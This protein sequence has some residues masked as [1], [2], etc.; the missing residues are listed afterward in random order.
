MA[1]SIRALSMDAVQKS[2]SGHPGMP[3]GFA[4]VATVLFN[5]FLKFNPEDPDW[6]D[7]DRFILSAG[8]GSMLLYS[9]LHLT[10]YEDFPIEQIRRFRQL[11][12]KTAGHPEFGHGG[13]IEN[14]TGP[15]GQGLANAVGMAIAEHKLRHE[16][17]EEIINHK[18][19]A[20]VGDGCLMEG[21]SYEA[22]SLAG[23]LKLNQLIVLWDDNDITIDGAKQ[24]A[25]NEDIL[26][27][28]ESQQWLTLSCDGHDFDSIHNALQQAQASVQ[29]VLIACKTI[30]G[31]GAVTHA[32]TA[33]VHGSPLGDDEITKAKANLQWSY[34]PFDI[35]QEIYDY[36]Q[37]AVK[38]SQKNYSAWQQ[39]ID[40]HPQCAELFRRIK[41]EL[42]LTM[43]SVCRQFK[44]KMMADSP[45][46]ATRKSGQLVL[47][48]LN[49]VLPE[50]LGGSADLT[51]SNL[52]QAEGQS[53]Y[54]VD[55]PQGSYIHFGI[56]EHGM[57]AALN[58][59]AL[60]GGFIPYGGTFLVFSDYCR[61][62][63]R[64]SALM[65]VRVIYVMTHDSI[66]L[67]EDG[68]T[69][70]PVETLAALRAIP[71]LNVFRPCDSVETMECWQ[72]ALSDR[73]R[74]TSLIALSRQN[75]P[76][77]RNASN[78]PSLD[79]NLS[80]QG[81]YVLSYETQHHQVTIMATGSE[82]S[83]ALQ[84][85]QQLEQQ[86]IGTR[87]VSLPQLER[88]QEN[89][90]QYIVETLGD[91]QV[92]ASVE[93][94]VKQPWQAFTYRPDVIVGLDTFGTSAPIE[95]IYDFFGINAQSLVDEI[96][97]KMP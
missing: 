10:G 79:D 47:N 58:G 5:D 19:Y 71:N 95:D 65:N 85:Q 91:Y 3:M 36:W 68:P 34:P 44:S 52:T 73:H 27:R 93:A 67:G 63:I 8:H 54:D 40:G 32:G 31:K 60:H 26:R 35:P 92:L 14:T 90:N 87:V 46:I 72:I 80:K 57:A 55:A 4:D 20:V 28:F 81:G 61:P 89:E 41:G 21:I 12:S 42:P 49:T 48:E 75:L 13:G 96:M 86:N 17:G 37:L 18:I 30:I 45:M 2:K 38:R 33:K 97:C 50:L 24:L 64:L 78:T 62:A 88:F 7:R 82:V 59:I 6:I 83:I 16:F 84:A 77:L 11:G 9:L 76:T 43:D 39:R 74:R 25:T 22:C 69:H 51:G 94:A 15:L 53:I 1:N 66:G 23:R 70:Q 29:P 56:R